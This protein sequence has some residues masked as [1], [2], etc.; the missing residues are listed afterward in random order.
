MRKSG[1][2]SMVKAAMVVVS[3]MVIG[4]LSINTAIAAGEYT[5]TMKSFGCMDKD[6]FKRV[7]SYLVAKDMKAFSNRLAAGILNGTSTLFEAGQTV[8]L[9]ETSVFSGMVKI[10]RVGE[11]SEYWTVMETIK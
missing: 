6:E 4:L 11:S 7:H 3:V 1:Q 10:R 5:I 9:I 8:F 2:S